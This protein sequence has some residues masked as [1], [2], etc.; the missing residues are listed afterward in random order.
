MK[1]P[2]SRMSAQ[3][4]AD[5]MVI[6]DLKELLRKARVAQIKADEASQAVFAALEDM[7]IELNAVSFAENADNLG[8][9]ISCFIVY[10]EY[11]MKNIISE[12]RKQYCKEE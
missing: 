10:G 8:D 6:N 11:G 9:A 1:K 12:I 4:A 7:C 2:I 3:E 5:E